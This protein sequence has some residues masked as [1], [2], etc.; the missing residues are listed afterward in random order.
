MVIS[1]HPPPP[2]PPPTKQEK[3][4]VSLLSGP[5]TAVFSPECDSRHYYI[6]RVGK[7]GGGGGASTHARLL[8][9]CMVPATCVIV[10]VGMLQVGCSS[11][12]RAPARP[13]QKEEEEE[14]EEEEAHL[15]FQHGIFLPKRDG[16]PCGKTDTCCSTNYGIITFFPFPTKGGEEEI[17]KS[18]KETGNWD[19]NFFSN[20]NVLVTCCCICVREERGGGETGVLGRKSRFRC[21]RYF[22]LPPPTC[23]QC[24]RIGT[25]G[26]RG[27]WKEEHVFRIPPGKK[28]RRC[29]RENV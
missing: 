1:M 7:R 17:K 14:E 28:G 9:L 13:L 15:S 19:L 2:P 3:K 8:H 12:T 27:M 25:E 23:L 10:E 6:H 29:R 4:K 5:F 20:K 16:T 22:F 24:V 21:C 11:L 18:K 26:E